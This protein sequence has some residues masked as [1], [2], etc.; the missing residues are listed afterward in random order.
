MTPMLIPENEIWLHEP[1]AS[2]DLL[3]ALAWAQRNAA[4]E[5]DLDAILKKLSD[6]ALEYKS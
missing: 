4:K 3:R 1:Q 5:S 6:G 2:Q